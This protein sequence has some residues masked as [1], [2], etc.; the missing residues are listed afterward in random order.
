MKVV[1]LISHS[2]PG[3][4][5]VLMKGFILHISIRMMGMTGKSR[6]CL[7][8]ICLLLSIA[9]VLIP[10]ERLRCIP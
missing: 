9:L 10:P 8:M 7:I 6:A 5:S 3:D 1:V 2:P 4:I